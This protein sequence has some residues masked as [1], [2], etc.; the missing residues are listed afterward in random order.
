MIPTTTDMVELRDLHK[1]FG[2]FTAA[3]GV[4]LS[5]RAGEFLT[6]LGPSGCGK[7]TLLRMVSG[8]ETP[9]A[10]RVLLD[11]AD[12]TDLPPYRRDVNQVFQSYALFPHLSVADNVAFGLRVRRLPRAEIA[13]RVAAGIELVSLTGLADRKPHQ[14][15]GG[16]RQRVALARA[17]VCEPKV[18]LLDEPLSALDAK[19]RRQ[20]QV[21]L[22]RLQ[23]RVGITFVFVT[24]DQEEAM[25]MSDRV[26]VM[27]AG[28]VEQLGTP[29]DV[30]HRPATAFVAT[31][32]GLANLLPC[33]V[34]D[35]TAG[36]VKLGD[37]TPFTC[38]PAALPDAADVLLM[39]RP[40]R[41]R[42]SVLPTPG[43]FP[44]RAADRLFR[45]PVEQLAV[46]TA[47]GTVLTC[48]GGDL[49]TADVLH[50]SVP[51]DA[52]RVV[53]P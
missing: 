3:G 17:L 11:G 4:S 25:T 5:I 12:V 29:A 30:Y 40:E 51:P 50:C 28:H 53:R 19:L 46:R 9:D 49:P 2:T 18:L 38:D 45:G 6:L 14:L 47:G 36:R 7:T 34:V 37:G 23:Q 24:H 21:E 39:V 32:L 16:Q 31:F 1:S 52:V 27:N 22:K 42:L 26:A 13:E 44:V 43:S 15:S 20:M 35:R 48:V 33:T 10:G 41:L 8:F